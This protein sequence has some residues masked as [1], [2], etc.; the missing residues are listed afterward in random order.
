MSLDGFIGTP[1]TPGNLRDML[2]RAFNLRLSGAEVGALF[3][4]FDEDRSGTLDGAEFLMNFKKLGFNERARRAKVQRESTTAMNK[5]FQ[6]LDDEREAAKKQASDNAVSFKFTSEDARNAIDKLAAKSADYDRT[7]ARARS[8]RAQEELAAAAHQRSPSLFCSLAASAKENSRQRRTNVLLFC[9]APAK[10]N[11][12]QRR[13]NELLLLWSLR[14]ARVLLCSRTASLARSP[15][16]P[17]PAP[18]QRRHRRR[19]TSAPSRARP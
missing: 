9:S 18:T 15:P 5:H 16:P 1:L 8:K 12:R 19:S 2:R 3:A 17:S 11:S 6:K 4:A 14:L 13:I 7:C 10:K